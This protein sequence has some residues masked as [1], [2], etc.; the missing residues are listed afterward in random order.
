MTLADLIRRRQ[1]FLALSNSD[2]W[3]EDEACRLFDLVPGSLNADGIFD[4]A[5]KDAEEIADAVVPLLTQAVHALE[6]AK[7]FGSQG[8]DD[9]GYS[10]DYFI[11]KAL[12]A[13]EFVDTSAYDDDRR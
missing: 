11:E 12:K 2:Q 7:A 9:D 13:T 6:K 4:M 8:T 3:S 10:V 1:S 5:A